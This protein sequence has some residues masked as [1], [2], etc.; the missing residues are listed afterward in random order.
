M[1]IPDEVMHFRN[2]RAR[3]LEIVAKL[4]DRYIESGISTPI[5]NAVFQLR[6][7]A[8]ILPFKDGTT[9]K[10]TWGYEIDN[11]TFSP[12]IP[13][14]IKPKVQSL[15][16]SL[17]LK[18]IANYDDWENLNDPLKE[19]SFRVIIRGLADKN[20]FTGFHIDRH[21]GV[22]DVEGEIHPLYHLQYLTNPNNEKIF[23]NG[24]ILSLDT[25]R[26]MHY[27]MEFILGIGYLTANFFPTAY[28]TLLNDGFFFNVYKKYQERI[29]KPYSHTLA[30]Y[31]K[32]FE[33]N[34]IIWNPNI[35]CPY[36]L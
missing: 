25:P 33:E 9:N 29:W 36:L 5:Y 31:W 7:K 27:P 16:I 22:E 26:I 21:D 24:S 23:D 17:N 20:Y 1:K 3:E 12:N 15:E 8:F 19:L 13:R 28:S 32:P 2:E 6:N 11:F 18:I 14:H 30:N 10:D 34:S 35:V 4:L